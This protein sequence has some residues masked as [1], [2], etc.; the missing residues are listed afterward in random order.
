MTK[1]NFEFDRKVKISKMGLSHSVFQVHSNFGIRFFIQDSE[2]VQTAQFLKIWLLHESW[3]KVK[4][5]KTDLS[6]LVFLITFRLWDLFLRSR[7]GNCANCPISRKLTFAQI[8]T[9]SQNFQKGPVSPNFSRRFQFWGLF[10]HLRIWNCSNSMIL[11]LLAWRW[12]L[13]MNQDVRAKLILFRFSHGFWFRNLLICF[14]LG[15]HICDP[16]LRCTS[17]VQNLSSQDQDLRFIH[18]VW[19]PS[20][21]FPRLHQGFPFKVQMN[22][23]SVSWT[24]N[25]TGSLVQPTIPVRCLPFLSTILTKNS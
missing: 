6:H 12:T 4:I 1:L 15:N 13:T 7:L 8:L 10:L 3:P 11:Q 21:L 19:I 20:R 23:T 14:G 22:L 9:K 2:I 18:L 24:W 16:L 5:F 17:S 25:Y